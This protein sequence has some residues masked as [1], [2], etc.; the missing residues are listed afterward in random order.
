MAPEN[1][2]PEPGQLRLF[3]AI[4]LPAELK[5]AAAGLINNLQKG[6][7][8]TGAHPAWV[9]PDALHQTLVFLGWLAAERLD[10]VRDAMTEGAAG[11]WPFQLGVAQVCL[12]PNPKMPKIIAM[13]LNGGM[14]ELAALQARHAAA[15]SAR[16]FEVDTRPFR[17]HL[18][19][20]RIKSMKG[21]AGLRDVVKIHHNASLGSFLADRITLYRSILSP[22][23]A[24]YE[25]VA[26]QLLGE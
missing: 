14:D 24:R 19:L 10:A 25:V 11:T 8:F 16:G 22:D 17:P 12:F 3:T 21:L 18:T 5:N 9:R 15:C 26:E 2:R 1:S 6:I 13:E 23:G 4:A 20:A 7:Q